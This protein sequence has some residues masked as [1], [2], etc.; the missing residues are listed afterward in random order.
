MFP[1]FWENRYVM[2]RSD[3]EIKSDLR[4]DP[5]CCLKLTKGKVIQKRTTFSSQLR[6]AVCESI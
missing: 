3:D 2:R 5:L 6:W 4:R 1:R